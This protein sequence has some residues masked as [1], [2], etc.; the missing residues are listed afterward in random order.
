LL[1]SPLNR[2]PYAVEAPF[3][4]FNRQHEPT[5][6]PETRVDLLQRIYSWVEGPDE[7][8]IFWLSGLAG[9]GKSTIARTV[10]RKY[11]GDGQ[12]GASFF[13]L[14]GG[15][16]VGHAGKFFT[17]IAL[18][19]SKK[20]QPLQG[21]IC[22]AI[23]KNSDIA[24]QSL[25]DQ[26]R[27]LVLGPLTKLSG[28]L[29]LSILVIDALDECDN[30]K[31]IQTILRLLAE[32]QSLK[33]VRLRVFLTSRPEIPIR[34]GFY[35]IPEAEHQ[36]FVLHNISPSIVDHD[37]RVFVEHHLSL[38]R[39]ARSLDVGWP[40]AEAIN[41]LV[42]NAYGL[43][44]WAATACRFIQEGKRFAAKR[45]RMIL[46]NSSQ[47]ITA[48]EKHLNDIYLTV[49]N[50]SISS[51]YSDEEKEELYENLRYILGS[52]A[53]LISPLSPYSLSKLL[54]VPKEEFD[55]TLDELHAILDV[56]QARPLYLHHPSFR[57]FLLDKNR[58][59]DPKFWVD[60]KQA[61]QELGRSCIQLLS[62]SLKEDICDV[63]IPGLNIVE[64]ES[65]RIEQC[66]PLEVQ[67]ACLY[68]VQHVRKGGIKL[69]DDDEIDQF[70]RHHFLHWLEALS[71][72]RKLTEG[73]QVLAFLQLITFVSQMQ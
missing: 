68:W 54:Y 38:I 64:V 30:D 12:L 19:L 9:T 15:G 45:L 44:I 11:L 72:M 4:T 39:Q 55:Q 35:Q 16:D 27:Q 66:I 50:H 6:L 17:T 56:H 57:D 7:R 52:I 1:A 36:D 49:L 37:I 47:S 2:L 22:D 24:T 53:I 60:E 59:N 28:D 63:K 65:S 10:A 61:H 5:C 51:D 25:G 70:L 14:R 3:N 21:H 73:I 46:E 40:G 41:C 23:R 67:Y 48:P 32:A 8:S 29:S 69:R 20:S 31:D 26:W 58:C 43:F 33:T 62:T 42:Q 13:F 71:W 34:H 18:Q